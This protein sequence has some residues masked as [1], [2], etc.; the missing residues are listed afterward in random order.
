[1]G[2]GADARTIWAIVRG[3]PR[4][5]TLDAR[6]DAFYG[7]QAERYDAFRERLLHGRDALLSD[8]LAAL[9]AA[10]RVVELGGGTGRNV[11]RF[12][13]R[14]RELE[15]LEVVDLCEPLLA[16][17]R[18]RLAGHTN[19]SLVRADAT[20]YSPPQPVDAVYC[21]YSLSMIPN[22]FAAVDNGLAMLRPGGLFGVVDFYVS[23]AHPAP[24]QR[25]HGIFTR[26]FWPLWF[27]HDGVCPSPDHLPYLQQRFETVSLH[28][29]RGSIPYLPGLK[30]PYYRFLGRKPL[31]AGVDPEAS[32]SGKH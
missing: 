23:R 28:E 27:G 2:L 3:Q 12:G 31:Q 11:E 4:R 16:V 30:A 8:L 18:T 29:D 7:P 17:A 1:M 15:S 26:H 5:D 21:S 24:G 13:P 20:S 9:P 32:L 10:A 6:L 19:V 25:R 14:L 22:W